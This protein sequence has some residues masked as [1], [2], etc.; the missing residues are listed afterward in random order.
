M[1]PLQRQFGR[2]LKALRTSKQL[3][4]EELA[5]ATN[6]SASFISSL[7]RGIDAPSFATLEHL[8]RAL[9][10]SARDLFDFEN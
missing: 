9:G 7:E 6:L 5:R 3:T 1:K 8:A 10:I 4:Q 2:R